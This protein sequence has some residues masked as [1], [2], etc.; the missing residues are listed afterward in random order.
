MAGAKDKGG[1]RA[2]E[3]HY[4]EEHESRERENIDALEKTL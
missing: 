1:R 3:G 2:R 4:Q